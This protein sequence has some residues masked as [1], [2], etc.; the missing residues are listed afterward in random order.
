MMAANPAGADPCPADKPDDMRW[1]RVF[2]GTKVQVAEVRRFVSCLLAECPARDALV[3][4]V[5]ELSANAVVHTASGTGGFFS[6]EVS[7]PRNGVARVA[8]TD[9]G[10][11]TE[12]AAGT[13]VDGTQVDL[14]D[15]DVDELPVC[16]L[17]LAL[18]AA[19]ASCWGYYETGVGRTVWAEARWPVAVLATGHQTGA[20]RRDFPEHAAPSRFIPAVLTADDP[21]PGGSL[22]GGSAAGQAARR[23][24]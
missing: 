5:S 23:P 7:R 15:L 17:G 22:T 10:G 18:V 20:A 1:E 14:D 4:C 13:P 3:T 24:R 6:V 2:A 19:T 21:H 16:G 11:P 9:A 12:P 8:V